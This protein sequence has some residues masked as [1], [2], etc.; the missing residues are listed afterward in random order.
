MN[1]S[2][3]G[4]QLLADRAG[5]PGPTRPRPDDGRGHQTDRHGGDMTKWNAERR[6]ILGPKRSI[7]TANAPTS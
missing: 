6:A 2:A 3:L 1:S 4:R 5:G 7:F